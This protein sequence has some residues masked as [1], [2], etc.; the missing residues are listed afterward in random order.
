[1]KK[2]EPW[3][4]LLKNYPESDKLNAVQCGSEVL[5]FRTLAL[6]DDG[7][8]YYG[9]PKLLLS[10]PLRRRWANGTATLRR[11][12]IWLRELLSSGLLIPYTDH[13]RDYVHVFKCKKHL[14]SDIPRDLRFPVL[15][16]DV[17]VRVYAGGY[18]EVSFYVP[19]SY[20]S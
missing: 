4:P 18:D 14:R 15:P 12:K 16:R 19:K 1:M 17:Y 3:T 7:G 13:G 20:P 9:D 10:G 8:N 5:F 6:T 2:R 11:V